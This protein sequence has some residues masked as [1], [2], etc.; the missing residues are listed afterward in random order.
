MTQRVRPSRGFTLI[1]LIMAMMMVVIC[2][3]M[4]YAS[5]HIAFKAKRSAEASVTPV[6]SVGAAMDMISRDFDSVMLPSPQ[7][8]NTTDTTVLY[9]PGTFT[10]TM[11]NGGGGGADWVQ[12]Y[13]NGNDGTPD[14]LLSEGVHRI[15]YALSTEVNPPALVRRIKRNLLD[16]SDPST[17]QAEEEEL[18]CRNVRSFT[19]RF[20]DGTDWYDEWDSTT[21]LDANGAPAIPM[22]LQVD[23]V[24]NIDG[25]SLPGEEPNTYRITRMIP[26][27]IAKA[28]D[29]T[30]TS[31]A[32]Q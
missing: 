27:P 15:E 10:G 22:L 17:A 20:F 21:L 7:T 11:V 14:I 18:I 23:I 12:F 28:V 24:I 25:I 32:T 6:R 5:L 16:N 3:S 19:V 9:L 4:L 31:T 2:A 26:L 29:P 13:S 1:E 8:L 30:Q